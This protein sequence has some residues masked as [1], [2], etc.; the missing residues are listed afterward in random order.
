P[1]PNPPVA[2]PSAFE[3]LDT[4]D[5]LVLDLIRSMPNALDDAQV[6]EGFIIINNCNTDI[7]AQLDNEITY[8][9]FA[10]SYKE[11]A[12]EILAGLPP[13][14]TMSLVDEIRLGEYDT[15][16]GAFEVVSLSGNSTVRDLFYTQLASGVAQ[17]GGSGCIKPDFMYQPG[18]GIFPGGKDPDPRFEVGFAPYQFTEI[19]MPE[20]VAE[21]FINDEER[22]GGVIRGR[23][24]V[25]RTV[26]VVA[27]IQ[28]APGQPKISLSGSWKEP[29]RVHLQFAGQ[30][31]DISVY[32]RPP[33]VPHVEPIITLQVE[34]GAGAAGHP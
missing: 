32:E 18:S 11:R 2:A 4:K 29:S 19:P 23:T 15:G 28:I 7:G 34:A 10:A 13:E 31:K 26:W 24:G 16:R 27:H 9:K 12:P 8:P 22:L 21:Q 33:S 3:G 5:M 1:R 25:I 14:I 20:A 30:L 6:L 17:V